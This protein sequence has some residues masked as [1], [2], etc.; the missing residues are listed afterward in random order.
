LWLPDAAAAA[1]CGCLLLM[2]LP[3]IALLAKHG[4]PLVQ[5]LPRLEKLDFLL[6]AFR[7]SPLQEAE[8]TQ[9]GCKPS[10][11]VQHRINST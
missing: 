3:E 11:V 2:L 5:L 10:K 1:G 4:E 8:Q 7:G 6:F 9:T